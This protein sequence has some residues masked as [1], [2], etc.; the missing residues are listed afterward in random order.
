MSS[1]MEFAVT[2]AVL[3]SLAFLLLGCVELRKS[4]RVAKL[5]GLAW[6]LF[7]LGLVSLAY[8]LF[9]MQATWHLPNS[10]KPWSLISTSGGAAIF[11]MVLGC[12]TITSVS[13]IKEPEDTA[14]KSEKLSDIQASEAVWPPAPRKP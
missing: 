9:I 1:I 11:F 8:S 5:T 13:F 12:F 14:R 2:P 6:V 7:S 4:D 3:L 10:Q